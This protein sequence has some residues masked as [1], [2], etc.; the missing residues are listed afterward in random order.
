MFLSGF[1]IGHSPL[2]IGVKVAT[3]IGRSIL[4]IRV[5]VQ[6]VVLFCLICHSLPYPL[7][8]I[9]GDIR[10]KNLVCFSFDILFFHIK[11][12]VI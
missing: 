9:K 6:H 2:D 11:T 4:E 7:M 8:Y 12:G 1:S 3:G 5:K 10:L